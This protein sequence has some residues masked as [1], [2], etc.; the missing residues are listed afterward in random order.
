MIRFAF[1][2]VDGTLS[3]PRY[4]IDGE[5]RIGT[6]DEGWIEFCETHKENSYDLCHAVPCVKEH[7][8]MLKKNGARLFVLSTVMSPYE[9]DAKTKFVQE[10]YPGL[11]DG[12]IYVEHDA[13]KIP[14]IERFAAENAVKI[15]ECELVEDT[16][17]TL[18]KANEKGI[19][20]MHLSMLAGG[21][22]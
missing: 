7:A 13:E 4:L 12:F 5:I 9:K 15:S 22:M 19:V 6:T 20:P 3:V 21:I 8:E 10:K 11:F 14:V 17:A 1:F 16:F 18:L 2:D